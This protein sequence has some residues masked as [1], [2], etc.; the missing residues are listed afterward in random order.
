[1]LTLYIDPQ[2]EDCRRLRKRLVESHLAHVVEPVDH[3]RRGVQEAHT[4]LDDDEAVR[5][6]EAIQARIDGRWNLLMRTRRYQS[7]LCHDYG[8]EGDPDLE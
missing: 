1:M 7:D 6:H 5:G 8:D 4:L 2:C 3:P